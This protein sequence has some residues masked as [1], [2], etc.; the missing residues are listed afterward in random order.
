MW[1]LY[2]GA[3]LFLAGITA[4]IVDARHKPLP[5]GIEVIYSTG[6]RHH[7]HLPGWSP[8]AYDLIHVC[9]WALVLCGLLLAVMGLIRYSARL[10]SN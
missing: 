6:G 2:G 7:E 5:G 3:A 8:T 1:R 4:F 10:R 9:G